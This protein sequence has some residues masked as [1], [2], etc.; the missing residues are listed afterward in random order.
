MEELPYMTVPELDIFILQHRQEMNLSAHEE[1]YLKIRR[2]RM[3]IERHSLED[4]FTQPPHA[5][6]RPMIKVVVLG[7][8]SLTQHVESINMFLER[9]EKSVKSR[10]GDLTTRTM[11]YT[12]T[13]GQAA[14]VAV[15]TWLVPAA[16]SEDKL[17]RS[18]YYSST[19]V[20]VIF[21]S[22]RSRPSLEDITN[23]W[24]PEVQR[25]GFPDPAPPV[26]LVGT[27][28]QA[29]NHGSE[30]SHQ[31][32]T[33]AEA[34]S[35]ARMYGVSKYIEVFND[36][37]HHINEVYQQAFHATMLTHGVSDLSYVNPPSALLDDCVFRE[38]LTLATPIAD[39][40]PFE[41]L[42]KIN[43][44]INQTIGARY[45][46]T[47]DDVCTVEYSEP[48][49]LVKP[50]PKIL[51]VRCKARCHYPS[52]IVALP[53]PSV[54]PT[55]VAHFDVLTG[56][57]AIHTVPEV[58]YY[59]TLDGS[60]PSPSTSRLYTN[61]LVLNPTQSLNN[62]LLAAPDDICVRIVAIG[63]GM[64]RSKTVEYKPPAALDAPKVTFNAAEG[65]LV[66]DTVPYLEYRYTLDGT[67]PSYD[68]SNNPSSFAY[69][70]PV[71]IPKERYTSQQPFG[72]QPRVR[73]IAFP[74]LNFPSKC[75]EVP[76][77]SNHTPP[78][79]SVN[80]NKAT[81][82]RIQNGHA[83][84]VS[85]QAADRQRSGTPGRTHSP[86]MAPGSRRMDS[87]SRISTGGAAKSSSQAKDNAVEF[88]FDQPIHLSHLSV[89][90]PGHGSGPSFYE[91]FVKSCDTPENGYLAVGSGTL[92]DVEGVQR[93]TLHPTAA[94]YVTSVDQV[95]CIFKAKNA[96]NTFQI[97]D[98]KVH[99]KPSGVRGG[100]AVGNSSMC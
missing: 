61:T 3:S 80:I 55:P 74:R 66:I 5:E 60:K 31:I 79:S 82:Q 81:L 83:L 93:M 71:M 76:L 40:D 4:R 54:T 49:K 70:R 17:L 23:V 90:T 67:L 100:G 58:R 57:F 41:R 20:F 46:V 51:R 21:F 85:Q 59:Y 75:V 32:I 99:G 35:V 77:A 73:V 10:V 86:I 52:E 84:R 27:H 8:E 62:S 53:V 33:A 7:T 28:A 98:M 26:I 63:S 19:T 65:V 92:D 34:I 47:F 43:T 13:G 25:C 14:Q 91:V 94:M 69:T 87:P 45:F 72:G 16:P 22:I 9:D 78:S 56:T 11:E 42:F 24:L 39:F 30:G 12:T 1:T 44:T 95:R 38:H 88:D 29:R 2:R 89:T 36:N 50:F 37:V 97:C 6:S 96:S 15:Q 18:L 48:I 64:F 68:T